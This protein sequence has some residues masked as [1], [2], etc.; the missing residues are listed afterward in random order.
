MS[1]ATATLKTFQ[2]RTLR[3]S[4]ATEPAIE[5][6]GILLLLLIGYAFSWVFAFI[7]LIA[8]SPEAANA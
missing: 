3:E 2:Q 7:A 8:L 5:V 6:A 1:A 4:V